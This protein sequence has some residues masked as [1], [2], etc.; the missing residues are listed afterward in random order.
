[1]DP[2]H[3]QFLTGILLLAL[4]IDI[5]TVDCTA[6]TKKVSPTHPKIT[7]R[8]KKQFT[9]LAGGGIPLSRESLIKFWKVGPSGSLSFFVN[10]RPSTALGIGTDVS[11]LYFKLAEFAST[12]PGV[13]VQRKDIV[14]VHVYVGVKHSFS[15]TKG[16]SPYVVGTVGAARVTEAAYKEIVD[17]VRV[18]YYNIPGRTRLAGSLGLGA[19]IALSGWLWFTMEAKGTYFH[20]DADVGVACLVRGGFRFTL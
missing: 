15:P 19:D 9:V 10:V 16:F 17:S 5:F 4:A 20:N 11:M 13:A 7:V 1:M 18:T 6:Q 3:K 8:P 12:F 14:M 2:R